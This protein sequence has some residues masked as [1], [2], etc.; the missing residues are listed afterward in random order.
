MALVTFEIHVNFEGK[1]K[2]RLKNI[3]GHL[4][5]SLIFHMTEDME[6]EIHGL[7]TKY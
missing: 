2:K 6:S 5:T 3:K 7:L 4:K 1:K